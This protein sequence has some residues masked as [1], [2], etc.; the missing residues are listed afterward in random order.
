MAILFA[1]FTS[2]FWVCIFGVFPRIS[3]AACFAVIGLHLVAIHSLITRIHFLCLSKVDSRGLIQ[4][5]DGA[6]ALGVCLRM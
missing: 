1:S 3:L 4:G 6:L 2:G 5:C